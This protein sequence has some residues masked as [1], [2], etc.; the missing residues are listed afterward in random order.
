M[1][2]D[3]S[4]GTRRFRWALIA[5]AL[6]A[7]ALALPSGAA[8]YVTTVSFTGGTLG[9]AGS[10]GPDH[11]TITYKPDA[12]GQLVVQVYDPNGVA[13]PLPEGCT[14]KDPNRVVCPAASVA[15]E[16]DS[17]DGDD[18]IIFDF[19]FA[20][21]SARSV[22]TLASG[23]SATMNGGLG[24]DVE[25]Y[26]GPAGGVL[27]GGPGNDTQ[28]GGAGVDAMIGGPGNDSQSGQGGNDGLSGGS[29]ND[30]LK[31]GPGADK[32]LCGGGDDTGVGG[33]GK[34]TAKGCEQGKA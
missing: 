22:T 4:G 16:V 2:E 30:K 29:G 1:R 10:P 28:T 17:G 13:D 19:L 21:F 8:A 33:G 26:Q 25:T 34:D 31:G 6:V 12:N 15:V 27:I 14:R 11:A 24:N 23:F 7:V 5:L 20:P 32:L 18:E 3:G 9:V